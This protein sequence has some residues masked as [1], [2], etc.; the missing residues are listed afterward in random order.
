VKPGTG[1][2]RRALIIAVLGAC[3]LAAATATAGSYD[4]YSCKVGSAL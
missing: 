4:V 1:I 2:L 3:A